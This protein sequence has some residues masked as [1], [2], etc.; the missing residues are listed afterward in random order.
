MYSDVFWHMFE[1]SGNI[2]AYLAYKDEDY[3]FDSSVAFTVE[4]QFRNLTDTRKSETGSVMK[5]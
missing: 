3:Y 1:Q 5:G 4:D 2:N